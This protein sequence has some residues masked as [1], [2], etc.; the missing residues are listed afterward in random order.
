MANI[1]LE[2]IRAHGAMGVFLFVALESVCVPWPT[3]FAFIVAV[4]LMREGRLTHVQA[5]MLITLAQL[6]GSCTAYVLGRAGDNFLVRRFQENER[7]AGARRWLHNWYERH[8]AITVF[9]SRLVGQVRPWSSLAAG[10]AEVRI[11]PFILWT[12]LGSLIYSEIALE[13][14]RVGWRFWDAHPS[15]RVALV[16]VLVVIFYGAAIV[17]AVREIIIYRRRKR[18]ADAEPTK[19]ASKKTTA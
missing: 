17:G 3:E 8:G 16:I 13:L 14:T 15:L 9:V 6:A 5:V 10:L 19:T 4:D 12:T 1:L 11:V 2:W 18:A 7:I